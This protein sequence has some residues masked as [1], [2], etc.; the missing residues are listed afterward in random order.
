[1]F[2]N[3]N[4]VEM[5]TWLSKCCRNVVEMATWLSKCCRNVVEMA[6]WLSKAYYV[7][8]YFLGKWKRVRTE[9]FLKELTTFLKWEG[10]DS[11]KEIF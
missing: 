9:G 8:V 4:V 5:A 1:M 11:Y 7:D 2:Q 6:T 3:A 10:G